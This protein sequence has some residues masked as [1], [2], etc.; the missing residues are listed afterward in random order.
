MKSQ[1]LKSLFLFAILS[2]GLIVTA[3]EDRFSTSA[4]IGVTSPIL[5][6]GI[7]F[8]I[9]MNPSYSLSSL[10]SLEGQVSY[11]Y[12]KTSSSFLS[13]NK[14]LSNSINTL[15]GGRLYLNSEE[16]TNRFYVNLLFGVNYNKEGLNGIKRDGEIN[17]GFSSGAFFELNKFLIGLSYDT[18]QNLILKVGIKDIRFKNRK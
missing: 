10:F 1:I 7:G 18:P 16:R 5:D 3:Q 11:L 17:A 9:G 12:T 2:Y 4:T 13:G 8:H 15:A 14:K 6:S